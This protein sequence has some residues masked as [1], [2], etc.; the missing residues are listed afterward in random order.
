VLYV[1]VCAC[2]CVYVRTRVFVYVCPC[3]FAQCKCV[4][5][6]GSFYSIIEHRKSEL[7]QRIRTHP[8]PPPR[9]GFDRGFLS[10]R[11]HDP[12]GLLKSL[13]LEF[14]IDLVQEVITSSKRRD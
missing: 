1:C 11:Q 10:D 12:R 7:F 9:T 4:R 3:V 5:G 13:L 6:S 8:P 14:G 2:A